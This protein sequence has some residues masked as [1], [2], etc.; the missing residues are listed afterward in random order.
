MVNIKLFY[1]ID[2]TF[3]KRTFKN[4]QQNLY[5]KCIIKE[6][7]IFPFKSKKLFKIVLKQTK[8]ILY[9]VESV[10]RNNN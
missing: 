9:F 5:P 1:S 2:F 10:K 3:S 6:K 8:S 4:T 7:K